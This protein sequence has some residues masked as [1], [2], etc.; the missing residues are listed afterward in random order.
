M[1]QPKDFHRKLAMLL[2]EIDEGRE[3]EDYLLSVLAKLE[4]S[5]IRNLHVTNGRLYVE[6][7][8]RFLPMNAV[9]GGKQ[10]RSADRRALTR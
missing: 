10:V 1:I 7:Q 5:F 6:D 4:N 3:K 2:A 8:G 9:D